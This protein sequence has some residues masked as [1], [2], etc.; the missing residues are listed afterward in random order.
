MSAVALLAVVIVG[1][2][3]LVLYR[4]LDVLPTDYCQVSAQSAAERQLPAGEFTTS[5]A[6][7]GCRAGEV[8]FCGYHRILLSEVIQERPQPC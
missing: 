1:L 4:T 5:E 8:H 7:S 2:H 6:D 3:D